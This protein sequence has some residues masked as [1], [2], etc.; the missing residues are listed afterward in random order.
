MR[1]T[2]WI[3]LASS[4]QACLAAPVDKPVLAQALVERARAA[5]GPADPKIRL[6][7]LNTP[8]LPDLLMQT[9]AGQWSWREQ[10]ISA[11]SETT[12][13]VRLETTG[14]E[15]QHFSFNIAFR[16]Q[17]LRNYLVLRQPVYR[18][19]ELSAS[20]FDAVQEWT[21]ASRLDAGSL[22]SWPARRWKARR[23]LPATTHVRVQD[24]EEVAEHESGARISL[25]CHDQGVTLVIPCIAQEPGFPGRPFRV[26]NQSGKTILAWVW[27][28][29]QVCDSAP[30]PA[31]KTKGDQP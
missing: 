6:Q 23:D 17:V 9:P 31:P 13:R 26:R 28:G 18:G 7:P 11:T 16:K 30:P 2:V 15:R 27:P 12:P 1:W 21:E 8:S 25:M 19:G 29:G 22:T 24:L 10:I 3:L 20:D 4:L 14:P 5:L